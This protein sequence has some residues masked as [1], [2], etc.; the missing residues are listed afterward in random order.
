M[1][2]NHFNIRMIAITE[3]D[4]LDQQPNPFRWF[5]FILP[6]APEFAAI[7]D[8]DEDQAPL[9][10]LIKTIIAERNVELDAESAKLV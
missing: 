2:R 8:R 1:A 3:C 9:Y 4:H 10:T 6:G 7:M 5:R